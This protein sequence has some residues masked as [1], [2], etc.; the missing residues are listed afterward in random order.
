MGEYIVTARR[1]GNNW[2][3]G[4]MTNWDS[5]EVILDMSFLG[6]GNYAATIFTDGVNAG[7][8][9]SDYKKEKQDITSLS[10][11]KVSMA[12]GGGFAISLEKL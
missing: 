6:D 3:I 12:A 2:Y 8:Q 7:K 5:R 11:L 4:G 9:A 1:I 10:K